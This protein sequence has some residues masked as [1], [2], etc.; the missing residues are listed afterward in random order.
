M[1]ECISACTGKQLSSLKY[2]VK[3]KIIC[4]ILCKFIKYI[5]E[6]AV[7]LG[8]LKFDPKSNTC[9]MCHCLIELDN[10]YLK[11]IIYRIKEN[12][13][14]YIKTILDLFIQITGKKAFCTWGERIKP[15]LCL[16]TYHL[17]VK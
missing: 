17:R 10:G 14:K 12:E 15:L 2:K 7:Q 8:H 5:F 11:Y 1:I 16:Y 3:F 9:E 13:T 4:S 6:A